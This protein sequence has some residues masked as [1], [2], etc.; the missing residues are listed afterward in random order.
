MYRGHLRA[1]YLCNAWLIVANFKSLW[2]QSIRFASAPPVVASPSWMKRCRAW[3]TTVRLD[4]RILN[5]RSTQ[6]EHWLR[7]RRWM[8]WRFCIRSS[9]REYTLLSS[10]VMQ[11]SQIYQ[12]P[13]LDAQK[14]AFC[15][16]KIWIMCDRG[17]CVLFDA[18]KSGFA[19][20]ENIS[21]NFTNICSFRS[22]IHSRLLNSDIFHS[23]STTTRHKRLKISQ[24]WAQDLSKPIGLWS[25][26]T[27]QSA[28]HWVQ[29]SWMNCISRIRV[30]VDPYYWTALIPSCMMLSHRKSSTESTIIATDLDSLSCK[31][32]TTLRSQQLPNTHYLKQRLHPGPQP[33]PSRPRY[34]TQCPPKVR[35]HSDIVQLWTSCRH[36]SHQITAL[37]ENLCVSASLSEINIAL[38]LGLSLLTK[39][40][41]RFNYPHIEG[42]G[43]LIAN[44][45]IGLL[46][47]ILR[48]SRNI[49]CRNKRELGRGR[50][51]GPRGW[52]ILLMWPWLQCSRTICLI[53]WGRR[54]RSRLWFPSHKIFLR[55]RQR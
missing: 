29:I 49:D 43:Q 22:E 3:S 6:I 15:S 4:E 16:W 1:Y 37:T 25:N 27:S 42:R 24:I 34:G 9:W 41:D 30:R 7:R 8:R 2:H 18:V 36:I 12:K 14:A 17:R 38:D 51:A 53:W 54:W 19:P 55:S 20:Y 44:H 31:E 35:S 32:Y 23:T 47:R 10:P 45:G 50:R 28:R 48:I 46:D 11:P 26:V 52:R 40:K 33:Y 13:C 5:H 39:S 21:Y